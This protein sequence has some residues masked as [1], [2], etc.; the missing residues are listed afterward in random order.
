MPRFNS[1][2]TNRNTRAV[3][4]KSSKPQVGTEDIEY[5]DYKNVSLLRRCMSRYMRIEG[6]RRTGLSA[7]QQ[8]ALGRAVK[9]ARYLALVP[10]KL[11]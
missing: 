4:P 6:R 1:T 5:F 2:N 3:R 11:S 8:R 9:R 7:K 10:Y